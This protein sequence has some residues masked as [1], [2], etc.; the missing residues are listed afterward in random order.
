MLQNLCV[1]SLLNGWDL[2]AV[3]FIPVRMSIFFLRMIPIFLMTMV[4]FF[5]V[6]MS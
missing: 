5:I 2:V 3:F 6:N 4:A 1:I